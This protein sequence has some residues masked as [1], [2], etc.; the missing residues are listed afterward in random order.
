M[1]VFDQ[2][3]ARAVGR[4][5]FNVH[6]PASHC[7]ATSSLEAWKAD[8]SSGDHKKTALEESRC[9]SGSMAVLVAKDY[10]TCCTALSQLRTWLRLTGVGKFVIDF[11]KLLVGRTPE[12]VMKKPTNSTSCSTNWNF[13]ELRITPLL[14]C[15]V[16]N[17]QTLKKASFMVLLYSKVLSTHRRC[18]GMCL[19]SQ[20]MRSV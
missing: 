11:T 13:V 4:A 19:V 12:E 14:S 16:R 18:L 10:A 8:L 2:S 7:F 15:R 20:S 3:E 9:L 1:A 6:T 5:G 17:L